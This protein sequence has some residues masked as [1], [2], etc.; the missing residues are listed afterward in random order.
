MFIYRSSKVFTYL[1]KSYLP[2][3]VVHTRLSS[4]VIINIGRSYANRILQKSM[5]RINDIFGKRKKYII[6]FV[7]TVES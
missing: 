5:D 6:F 7:E 1:R 4:M 2:S 3:A